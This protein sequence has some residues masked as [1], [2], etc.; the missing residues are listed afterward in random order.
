[1]LILTRRIGERIVINDDI[2]VIMLGVNGCQVKVGI[3][4]PKKVS[5]HR[6][7]IWIKIQEEK[8]KASNAE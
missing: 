8:Q 7:E 1:M 6:K 5:V 3:I 2:E 4:A